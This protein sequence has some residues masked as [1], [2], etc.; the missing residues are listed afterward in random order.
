MRNYFL[1]ASTA[2]FT[3]VTIGAV[4]LTS[5][6]AK[7][8]ASDVPADVE[9]T[10]LPQIVVEEA[11]L[12][13]QTEAH[14][15]PDLSTSQFSKPHISGREKLDIRPTAGIKPA[16][17]G[18]NLAELVRHYGATQTPNRESECLAVTVYFEA[19]SEPLEGQLAVAET[20]INRS[21][22]GR[23]PSSLCGVLMQRGQFSF[24]RGGGYPAIARGGQQ[25]KNAV[26]IAQIAQ[27]ELHSTPVSTALFFHA[28]RVSPGWKLRRIGS[29]GNHVFYR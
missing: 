14:P 18:G 26:A 23:F 29:V 28:R 9:S 7:A 16:P 22:S 15:L 25:W 3:L 12:E 27:D 8:W 19:K 20:V 2:V 5:P 17:R 10:L 4:S 1:A 13:G 6:A 24:V 21:R 11:K